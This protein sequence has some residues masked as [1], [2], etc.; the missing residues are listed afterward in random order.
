[1]AFFLARF[2]HCK[3]LTPIVAVVIPC[4]RVA[5]HI[6]EVLA[7]IGDEVEAIYVVDDRCPQ[8]TGD[9]VAAQCTD[10]RVRILRHSENQGVGGATITGYSAAVADGASVIVK[11]DGDGQMDPAEIP[12]L[13]RPI[14]HGEAD[15]TKGNRFFELE[16]LKQMPAVRLLGNAA[17]SFLSKLSTG[18]WDI[19]DPTN[20]YTAIHGKVAAVVPFGKISRRYFFESDMLFRLN[21]LRAVVWD[22]PMRARYGG[23]TSSL[24]VGRALVEFAVKN[25]RNAA[26]RLFYNYFL[27]SFSVAS[28]E[29]LL[30]PPLTFAGAAFGLDRWVLSAA[31]GTL[32]TSGTVMLAALPIIVGV[33][34]SLAFLSYDVQSVPKVPLQKRL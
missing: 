3:A 24:H 31:R 9:L 6:L 8:G 26:K 14:L 32:A 7:A 34:L 33:Q 16:G 13:V 17:L 28:V 19:F 25:F 12:R 23:E 2:I 27:R 11:L 10:P 1:V 4:F 29:L 21:T 20:G 5:S 18:Y 15:Y 30:G 22:V